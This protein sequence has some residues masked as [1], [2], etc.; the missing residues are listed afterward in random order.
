MCRCCARRLSAPAGGRR[1]GSS[2]SG[3]RGLCLVCSKPGAGRSPTMRRL[4]PSVLRAS[5]ARGSRA[6]PAGRQHLRRA[7][8]PR[9]GQFQGWA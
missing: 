6:L 4:S 3:L 8:G 7:G 9:G 1:E 5:C 2:T